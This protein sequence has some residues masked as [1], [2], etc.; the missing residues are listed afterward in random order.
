[1]VKR[2]VLWDEV[3]VQLA[4]LVRRQEAA[5]V[6]VLYADRNSLSEDLKTSIAIYDETICHEVIFNP[7]GRDIYYE[8][9]LE[10][11]DVHHAVSRFHRLCRVASRE[12][13]PALAALLSE[14]LVADTANGAP[15][16]EGPTRFPRAVN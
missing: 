15:S 12:P 1:V 2:I 4:E 10:K 16:D 13:P 7:D 14:T 8:Y 6:E 5:G 3:D 9:F 11:E